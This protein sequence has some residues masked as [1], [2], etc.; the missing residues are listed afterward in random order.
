MEN[1]YRVEFLKELRL[2]KVR[3]FDDVSELTVKGCFVAYEKLVE[4]NYDGKPFKLMI[5]NSGYRP[6]SESAHRLIRQLFT[7]QTYKTSCV[8]VAIVNESIPTINKRRESDVLEMEG[9]FSNEAEALEWVENE[10]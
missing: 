8:R 9:F 2:F 1:N 10:I 6:A 7:N 4:M 3:L 5:N